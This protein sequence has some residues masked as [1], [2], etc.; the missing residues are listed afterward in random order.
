MRLWELEAAL[1]AVRPFPSPTIELE[2]YVTPAA[3]AARLIHTASTAFDDVAG[4][5][6]A[7]FGAGT[8]VLGIAAALAGAASVVA[9]DVDA[10]ALAV[11]AANAAAAGVVLDCVVADI[12]PRPAAPPPPPPPPWTRPPRRWR[13]RGCPPP[14]GAPPPPVDTVVM[15]P[16][17]GTRVA[18]ADVAF[19][20]AAAHTATRAVYSLHKTST[21]AHVGAAAAASGAVPVVVARLRFPLPRAYAFHRRAVGEVAVDLWRLDTAAVGSGRRVV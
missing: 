11:A 17:F 1:G 4:R 7:D 18:G 5:A 15:N 2:Q 6:V 13:A 20:L 12:L 3:L 10:R 21:R 8:G 16:P 19:L 14:L 9:V